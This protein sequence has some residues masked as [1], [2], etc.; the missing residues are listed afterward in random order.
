MIDVVEITLRNDAGSPVCKV[1]VFGV[2]E[3]EFYTV[4][5]SGQ[6]AIVAA[7]YAS[8]GLVPAL[9][10]IRT[11]PTGEFSPK[12]GSRRTGRAYA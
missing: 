8:M 1:S 7:K 12:L 9:L 5:L 4:P 2:E 6:A 10:D 3:S 11:V